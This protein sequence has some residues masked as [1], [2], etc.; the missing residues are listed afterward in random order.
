MRSIIAL[1]S[2]LLLFASSGAGVQPQRDAT[3]N[4]VLIM[5][6][7]AGYADIGSYGAP[8]TRTP[9]IDSL[10]RDGV[11]L[12]DFYANAMSCT[13]TRA[14]LIAGRY[15]QR[16]GIEFPFPAPGLPGADGGLPPLP[17]SL[18]LLLRKNG[19]A[20]ALVGKWHLGYTPEFSPRSHGF[21][22]FFG[23]KSAAIDYY[24][25][26]TVRPSEGAQFS[27][28]HPDLWRDDAL[29]EEA[30]Y[31]TDLITRKAV[32]FINQN[33]SRPFFIDVAFNAPHSPTQPPDHPNGTPAPAGA[34]R[35][36]YVAVMER[37]DRGVGEI[38][39]ALQAR[40]LERNTI[41][42]FTND[43][44][45]IGL[46]HSAPLFHRKFSAW[47]GGIRVPALV[48]WPGRIP[49]GAVSA[50]VGI[51]MDLSASILVATGTPVPS[52]ARLEGINLF[53]ILERKAPEVERT[54]FWRTSGPSPVNMNQK[55]VRSGD[56]K[57]I[58]DGAVT[59]IFLFNVKADPGERVDLFA[60]HQ[61]IV[62]RLQQLLIDWERDVEA[63]AKAF[64]AKGRDR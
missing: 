50:Q 21:D 53:P 54:L 25:H 38:L 9:N 3:P 45:G 6:D 64:A 26:H 56:W 24:T 43:N 29:I 58:I 33:A 18:P 10:A 22:F 62:R 46:S 2:A 55:A 60:R 35:A 59:R 34:T 37:V 52:D 11:K 51:T 49:A 63:D 28:P 19:Y 32:E 13:P 14:G 36:D 16:Y 44:G 47:E 30:G 23:S 41:V 4:V 42:I 48:R 57:L 15:Q 20:T 40:G 5:T 7:D 1:A 39:Q 12:T 61:D 8:D 27:K 17:H 31:M